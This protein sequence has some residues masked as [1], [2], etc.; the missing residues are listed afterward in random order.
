MK[1]RISYKRF[2]MSML[3]LY[4]ICLPLNAINLGSWGAALKIFAILPVCIAL[5]G[6]DRIH[7]NAPVLMQMLFTVFAFCSLIWTVQM[8]NST[9]R[10]VSYVLLLALLVS[11]AS[12]R[13][14]DEDVQRVK[15]ALI[16]SSRL[17]A[18]VMLVF[19]EYIEGRFRLMGVVEEDPNY[20]CAYLVFGVVHAVQ[21]LSR[22]DKIGI[23]LV[24]GLELIVYFYLTLVSGSRGGLLAIV[25]A[26][27]AFLAV[28]RGGSAKSAIKRTT[29][30]LLTFGVLILLLSLLPE[31]LSERFTVEHVAESGGSGRTELWEQAVDLFVKSSAL[32]KLFGYGTATVIRCFEQYG[33]YRV[34]VVHNMFLETL[35]E[36]GIVGLVIYSAAIYAFIR[37]SYKFTDKYSFAVILS[38]LIMSLSTSIYTFKPYFN[39][40]LFII[41]LQ[42]R[43]PTSKK[44]ESDQNDQ[45]HRSNLQCRRLY[46]DMY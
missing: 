40:M 4:I 14:T 32:R 13:Y 17:T 41:I 3:L 26:V 29:L 43:Q 30:A 23:K 25:G 38:M 15:R 1:R 6:G 5:F 46:R 12:F 45:H 21:V 2:Y 9:E 35:V 36:L 18:V 16:W 10:V 42:S 8:D 11:G 39:A 27:V 37:A 31:D 28:Y 7:L 19:A 44:K 33:Y 34:N 22:K 20:L 24:S